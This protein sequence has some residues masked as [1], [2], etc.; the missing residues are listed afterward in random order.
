MS[1]GSGIWKIAKPV[2][3]GLL[4]LVG[5]ILVGALI[6]KLA[7]P[8]LNAVSS[9]DPAGRK[10]L[11]VLIIAIT[12]LIALILLLRLVWRSRT[13]Y[14]TTV[15]SL[16]R[17]SNNNNS[18]WNWK[19][20]GVIAGVTILLA[21]L[22]YWLS[23]FL[24]G[25]ILLAIAYLLGFTTVIALVT[26]GFDEVLGID[27]PTLGEAFRKA[28]T[29]F[30]K[31]NN[32]RLAYLLVAAV[33][34]SVMAFRH[35]GDPLIPKAVQEISATADNATSNQTGSFVGFLRYGN[36]PPKENAEKAPA[37]HRTWFWWI[38][39]GSFWFLFVIYTPIAL[40]EEG[41]VL[42]EKLRE[43]HQANHNNPRQAPAPAPTT[44]NNPNANPLFGKMGRLFLEGIA[45]WVI[46]EGV[47]EVIDVWKKNRKKG[48]G[49]VY[50]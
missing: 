48:I 32:I 30:A 2:L 49:E 3:V 41:K 27:V 24:F 46:G 23:P 50:A 1:I 14:S 8:L 47:E 39:A 5:A 40:R 10:A 7:P 35:F 42:I 22:T 37:P 9:T 38:A 26:L 29:A 6:V 31:D 28:F 4:F 44:Q 16:P 12:A 45:G 33:I 21:C 20:I 15:R 11:G 13:G 19:R 18:T 36:D 34:T 43:H 25:F 17:S